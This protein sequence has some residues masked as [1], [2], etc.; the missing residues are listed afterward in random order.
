MI[1]A[2]TPYGANFI[3]KPVSLNIVSESASQSRT[4]GRPRSPIDAT[5]IAKSS[6]K[7]T[8][9]STSFS[10]S[11]FTMLV[12]TIETR[13]SCVVRCT[14]FAVISFVS[15]VISVARLTPSPGRTRFTAK[16]PITSA[17]SV[18]AVNQTIARSPS[19]PTDFKSPAP[20]MPTTSVLK[21]S[22]AISSL[23]SARKMRETTR[24]HWI[25]LS[26]VAGSPSSQ[27]WIAQPANAPS[28]RLT[29]ICR[30]RVDFRGRGGVMGAGIY[31]VGAAFPPRISG[32]R[33][34]AMLTQTPTLK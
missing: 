4:T 8:I 23:I 5:A 13:W 20:A 29:R 7:T 2:P 14:A 1:A 24:T 28:G 33:M 16:R 26:F 31:C 22:G 3:T 32:A 34:R 18:A 12:G 21:S 9:C 19:R 10:A 17:S 11:A 30:V 15:F 25:T 27:W 6:A